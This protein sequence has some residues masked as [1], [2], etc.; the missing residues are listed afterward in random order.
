MKLK[1]E[2]LI[3][4]ALFRA[5]VNNTDLLTS[6][7]LL[8]RA[9]LP[10]ALP[11]GKRRRLRQR[12]AGHLR[13]CFPE[14]SEAAIRA[15]AEAFL[16]HWSAKFAED[17][18]A[19]NLGG[20]EDWRRAVNR[21]VQ[22]QAGHHLRQALDRGRGILVVGCHLGS[23]S[24][25]TN[26]LLS[27]FSSVPTERWPVARMCAEPEI[28]AFPH[29]KAKVE[30]VL[31]DY[32]GDVGFIYTGWERERI[33]RTMTETLDG[34]GLV[35]TNIDVLMGGQSA[36][37]FSLF[38]ARVR[39]YLP[40]LV[41]AARAALRS[42]ATVLPWVNHRTRAG[43]SIR[44]EQPIGPLPRLGRAIPDDHPELLALCELLRRQLER[45]I[46]SCP[47]Q[48]IYWDRL[49]HRLVRDQEDDA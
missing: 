11:P 21:H 35:T 29:V 18:V 19:L 5:L 34:A 42:G 44:L 4:N 13:T 1:P 15:R 3:N 9:L 36:L 6:R 49:H 43:F 32:G 7:E 10:L 20:L 26:A 28:E 33:A 27:L 24:F 14:Q 39:V 12:V 47:E 8:R 31:R 45:W 16:F 30:E 37:P 38:G 23:T 25:C 48:W 2:A 22:I 41:G 46:T 40:A 17:A